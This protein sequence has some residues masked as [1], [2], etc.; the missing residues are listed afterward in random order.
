[1]LTV[2]LEGSGL[3]S[4]QRDWKVSILTLKF[5]DRLES[6]QTDWKVS[7]RTGKFLDRLESFQTDCKVLRQ[8]GKCPTDLK[9]SR[10]T[11]KFPDRLKISRQAG[12]VSPLAMFSSIVIFLFIN[13][14]DSTG[15][16]AV[17][18]DT[19]SK[20]MPIMAKLEVGFGCEIYLV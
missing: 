13:F 14:L 9:V 8:A 10:K 2:S 1:M 11:R 6:F 3:K 16:N 18:W 7:R 15:V 19:F 20:I 4:F 5:P 12:D 17:H